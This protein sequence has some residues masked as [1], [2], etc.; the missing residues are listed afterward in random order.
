MVAVLATPGCGLTGFEDGHRLTPEEIQALVDDAPYPEYTPKGV[1]VQPDRVTVKPDGTRTIK[2]NLVEALKLSLANNQSF[3][4]SS[5]NLDVQLLSLEVLRRSWWPLQSPLAGTVAWADA[6]DADPASSESLSASVSQKLPYGGTA[7]LSFSESG[8]Q[9]TGPNLYGS[10]L[11]AG[12]SIPLFRGGGW[13]LAVE[14]KVSAER[15]YVYARRSYEYSRTELLIQTVQSFFGQ[16]Q[17][18]VTIAN[19]ER[20]LESTKR[21]VELA[22]LKF[23]AG[24]VTRTDVFRA[25]LAVSNAQNS[26][27]NTRE[28]ARL[29]LDAFKI[30]LG[31]RPED[32]LILEKETIQFKSLTVEPKEAIDGAFAT[33]PRWLN[34]QDQFD[35]AGR[36][37]EIAGNA[38]LPQVNVSANY[39]W[40]QLSETRP[41]EE[42]ETGS[43]AVALG[44][45]FSLDLDRSTVNRDYQ[46]A[47]IRHRQA[48]RGF[49]RARDELARETQRL[50]TLL[51]QAEISMNLQ[52]RAKSDARRNLELLESQYDRGTLADNLSL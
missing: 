43:R 17:Q 32:E 48:Q 19:L 21:G 16:L 20:N 10:A 5:E 49:Q 42:F 1:A 3:L 44:M 25:E 51:R 34:A 41:F 45:D 11:T 31:L 28:Q 8:T 35:D 15:G 6:K 26:L 46:A 39:S 40:I 36:D 47:V 7:S 52:D 24:K 4:A 14:G 33:N 50:L 12:V 22:T 29:S 23:G 2:L 27:I 38:T 30:D 9:G 13:R 18:E 37:L